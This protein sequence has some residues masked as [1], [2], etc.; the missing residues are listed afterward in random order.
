MYYID[1]ETKIPKNGNQAGYRN[2]K[3]DTLKDCNNFIKYILDT[4]YDKK[5]KLVKYVPEIKKEKQLLDKKNKYFEKVKSKLSV[6]NNLNYFTS[7]EWK[8]REELSFYFNYYTSLYG[9]NR[10]KYQ[11]LIQLDISSRTSEIKGISGSEI[12]NCLYYGIYRNNFDSQRIREMRENFLKD[13]SII[14]EK[15]TY[16]EN[17]YKQF[18]ENT[19]YS[20]KYLNN[21]KERAIYYYEKMKEIDKEIKQNRLSIIVCMENSLLEYTTVENLNSESVLKINNKEYNIFTK[22]K[23]KYYTID[24]VGVMNDRYVLIRTDGKLLI[25]NDIVIINKLLQGKHLQHKLSFK[26]ENEI[27][28]NR[29][30]YNKNYKRTVI[31][32]FYNKEL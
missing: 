19:K 27:I 9:I 24:F 29:K 22:E 11:E 31:E 23:N 15:I 2:L 1:I 25:N 12:S 4:D 14:A 7:E 10:L 16:Y 21:N 6:L 8:K 28:F 18:H 5:L 13:E 26:N 32:N 20:D 3:F 30:K 17:L